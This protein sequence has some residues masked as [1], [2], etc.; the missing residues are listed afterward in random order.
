MVKTLNKYIIKAIY[1][2]PTDDIILSVR[3]LKTFSL[4]S[5]IRQG[6]LILPLVFNIVLF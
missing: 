1:D 6:C 3:R 4:R 5:A 2:K